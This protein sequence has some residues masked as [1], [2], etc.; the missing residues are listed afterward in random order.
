MQFSRGR[1]QIGLVGPQEWPRAT[2]TGVAMA[3]DVIDLQ[4]RRAAR[5]A[6][7]AEYDAHHKRIVAIFKIMAP[8]IACAQE[9]GADNQAIAGALRAIVEELEA[10]QSG[11][12]DAA[13]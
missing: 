13:S 10:A 11:P 5:E 3:K 6:E 4:S 1:L 7:R 9:L 8:V 12:P 2:S